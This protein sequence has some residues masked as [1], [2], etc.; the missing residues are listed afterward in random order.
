MEI[1]RFPGPE[2]TIMLLLEYH[3]STRIATSEKGKTAGIFKNFRIAE[4]EVILL[5]FFSVFPYTNSDKRQGRGGVRPGGS[6]ERS[7]SV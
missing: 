1:P 3:D 6:K 7:R 2:P 4:K 5:D